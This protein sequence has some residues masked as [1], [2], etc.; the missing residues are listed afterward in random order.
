[1]PTWK[2]FLTINL[3]LLGLTLAPLPVRSD[4]GPLGQ[5]N[6]NTYTF[7]QPILADPSAPGTP[8]FLDYEVLYEEYGRQSYNQVVANVQEWQERFCNEVSVDDIYDLVYK[9]SIYDVRELVNSVNNRRLP[10]P[11]NLRGNGFARYIKDTGCDETAV[12]LVFAKECEPYVVEY[13]AWELREDNE[14]RMRNL[15]ERGRR[16][17]MDTESYYIRLRYAYQLI[18]LAHYLRDYE[19]TVQLY[20]YL[21]PKIDNDPSIIEYWIMGHYAGALLA[22][23]KNV[24]ASYLYSLIFENSVGKRES[25]LQSF[26]LKSEEDW[27][28]CLLLC[29]TDEERATI[30]ALRAY[31]RDSKPL[32][33]MKA[34]YALDPDSHHLDVL[35]IKELKRL[36]KNLLGLSFNPQKRE[37]QSFYNIPRPGMGQYV[38]SF[39]DFVRRHNQTGKPANA[40]LWTMAEGYLEAIAGDYYAAQKILAKAAKLKMS[41]KMREQ[42]AAMQIVAQV[43]AFQ[44]VNEEVET[45]IAR[46]KFDDATY[47]RF[48]DFKR[49]ISDKMS[50]LYRE[51]GQEGKLFLQQHNLTDLKV[52]PQIA[53]IDELLNVANAER[54]NRFE[55]DLLRK[56][57]GTSMRN[58]L[59]DIKATYLMSRGEIVA[60]LETFREIDESR[61]ESYGLYNPFEAHLI[62][63]INCGNRDSLTLYSKP[64][65]IQRIRELEYKALA[66]R[67]KGAIYFYQIGLAYYNMS[68]FGY[69][70]KTTDY[71]RSGTSINNRRRSAGGVVP[72]WQFDYGNRENFNTQLAEEYFRKTIQLAKNKELAATAAFMAA[73]CEQAQNYVAGEARTYR[74]FNLLLEEYADTK[75]YQ[76]AIEECR[77][78]A[79]YSAR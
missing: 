5:P 47:E 59:I 30:H 14:D 9:A 72:T 36:E 75:F 48:P 23:G 41:D 19:L 2:L 7:L 20:D 24:E 33:D 39:Q 74:Y 50:Q 38:I 53:V 60:A 61:W 45:E 54:Q 35:L 77:H 15:I 44:T 22:Q 49:F 1:M 12:Y 28:N 26:S 70:W 57:D 55:R 56:T 76:K 17:F 40:V 42:L 31:A 10:L 16:A 46:I 18:R 27:K 37:N 52:N 25:A 63:C 8:Y 79:S 58:D 43:A 67:E 68:Y 21:M 65:I 51:S 3:L 11:I 34:I 78:F 69:A 29:K 6:L 64:A 13:D 4:C 73:K 71:F 62:D 66:D 32:D